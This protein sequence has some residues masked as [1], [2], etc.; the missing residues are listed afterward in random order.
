[1]KGSG[2]FP[3][4][5]LNELK[6][7]ISQ[8]SDREL[9]RIVEVECAD[10]RKEAIEFAEVEL[11]KRSIPFEKPEL[12][13]DE[14]EDADS[15]VPAK[16]AVACG[17]CGGVMR[18]GLLFAEK[19]LTILFSDSNEER[20]VQAFACTACGDVRLTVDLETEVEG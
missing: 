3:V 8:M 16:S 11:A 17:N 5:E 2:M 9:L 14:A 18:S 7:K 19:E 20:F 10:Y 4:D 12:V 13:E 6:D 15:I 1:M